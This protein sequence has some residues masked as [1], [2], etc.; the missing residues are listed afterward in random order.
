[1]RCSIMV[2]TRDLRVND[3]PALA[4]AS[5]A[6]RVVPLFV[7]DEAILAA[8]RTPVKRL[9]FLAESLADIDARL[10]ERG[11]ALVIRRGDWVRSVLDCA[12]AAG[13]GQIHLAADVTSY[14]SRRLAALRDAAAAD[15][16]TVVTHPGITAIEPG[17]IAPPGKPAYQ[18]FTPYYSRW[19]ET[20]LRAK[21]P[22]PGT[23]TLPPAI[24]PGALPAL[25]DLTGPRRDAAG[26][27][28]AGRDAVGRD[29]PGG[30]T[31][32]L[33]RLAAW[34]ESKLAGYADRRDDL[35]ADH[36]SHLSAYLHLGCISPRS[37]AALR[38][39]RYGAAFAR[40]IA[41][42]DFFHQV[43]A[44]RPDASWRDFRPR[45]DRWNRDQAAFAAW[46]AGR[47][48]YPVID[49]G[50]RQLAATG[51][52]P[53]RARMVVASFLTKDLYLDW[54]LGAA[55]FAE[56]LLDADVACNRLNWQWVA[57]TGTDTSPHRIF[58]PTT[59]GQRYD[60][61]GEYI[62]RWL[63]ELGWLPAGVIHDPD[64]ASRQIS[65][66]PAPLVDH[67]EAINRYRL[68]RH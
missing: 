49:A 42:R 59:Q 43:L 13:A 25:A 33:A 66:Y 40:Q 26:R 63:P 8:G 19:L 16:L 54:R 51:Y 56:H 23:I 14:A 38:E 58:N 9:G 10:R 46:Q 34:T 48:G 64:P 11:G 15:G 29:V 7:L 37:T 68:I 50:M 36:T 31:A 6:A 39:H 24:D 35:A 45:G 30:E 5:E 57:G 65:G 27:D 3:N 60:P 12:R 47:T 55:H 1:M 18:V 32:G 44:V 17:R 53:G 28:A 41:W 67:R 62:R 2:F 61:D 21:A 20:P 22:D 52:L 4:A